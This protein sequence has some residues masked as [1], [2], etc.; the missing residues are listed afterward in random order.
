MKQLE[1]NPWLRAHEQFPKGSHVKGRVRNLT[2]FGAFVEL[3]DGIDGMIHVSDMSW[4]KKINHP[5]EIL[6]KGDMVEAVVLEVEAA[7]QRISLGM[8][9]LTDDPWKSVASKYKVGDTVS[10]KVSKLASFGAF[11][12]LG[13][14]IEGLVPHLPN[15]RGARR[16]SQK[17]PQ[18]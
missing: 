15:Q 11:I 6:K 13:E 1:Q 12:D 14:G 16:E 4:T 2:N 8:K 7:N 17:R 9:Q 5:Q 18:D 3:A 10:G